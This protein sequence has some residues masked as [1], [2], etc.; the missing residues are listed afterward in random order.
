M[1]S[2]VKSRPQ[3]I[4]EPP[5]PGHVRWLAIVTAVV[6]GSLW[7][8]PLSSSLWEDE[9]GTWWVVKDGLGDAVHRAVTFQG[10]SPLYYLIVWAA[11]VVGGNSEVILRLPS[12]IAAA[13]SAVVLYRLARHLFSREAARFTVLVFAAS[14]V[15]AFEASEARPYAIA[16]LALIGSTY[17]LVRWLD[18][19]RRWAPALLYAL[20]AVTVVWLHYLF[21]LVL[22]AHALYALTRLRRGETEATVRRLAAVTVIVTAGI[23]PLA[24]Q[25]ASLWDRRS[26]LSIP[27]EGSV[28]AFAILLLPPV[29][30]ASVFLGSLLAS[31]RDRVRVAPVPARSSTFVLLAGWLM[32]PVVTL[33]L[34]SALTPVTF[35]S[36]RY[37]ASVGPA[38]AL[39]AGWG[40]ASLEPAAVRRT[41]A[42]VLAMLSVLAYGGR[43]KNSEDWRSAAAFERNH[44]DPATIVL[45]HPELVESAQLDWFSD[46]ERRSYLLSVQSYYPMEGRVTPMPYVLDGE[47]R[48]YL[49]GLVTG[50]LAGVDRFLLVTRDVQVPFREWLDGRLTS[51]GYTSKVIGTFG[52]IQVIEFSRST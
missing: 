2:D 39:F 20:L 38:I 46:P 22:V 40:I 17:A 12:L 19:G 31:T 24:V 10:Q 13:L 48:D 42:I 50:E 1:K 4:E 51:E 3:P 45:L 36:P 11:R 52:A 16:T 41:V 23:I 21:A 30:V 44:A 47:S 8:V 18:D 15:A 35:L 37:F 5:A 14:Q 28:S 34:V 43:M 29:L 32:I 26:S 7:L 49:E 27:S 25:L 33:F 6:I 9:F